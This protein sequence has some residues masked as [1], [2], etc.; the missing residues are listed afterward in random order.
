MLVVP[1]LQPAFT[2]WDFG[3]CAALLSRLWWWGTSR[4]SQLSQVA[5]ARGIEWRLVAR[6][7]RWAAPLVTEDVDPFRHVDFAKQALHPALF[8]SAFGDTAVFAM[9][10]SGLLGSD[11][12]R[13][14][15]LIIE[16][17]S[18]L[19]DELE[20]AAIAWLESLPPHGKIAYKA[21]A[22]PNVPLLF[23]IGALFH[24]PDDVTDGFRMFG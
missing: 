13:W 15:R 3:S 14:R 21:G 10:F 19:K 7:S 17:I 9:E 6:P 22:C 16:E 12:V 11:I 5:L 2:K 24:S 4:L 8:H 18:E 20:E 23:H 1:D